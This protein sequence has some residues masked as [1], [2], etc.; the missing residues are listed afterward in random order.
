[1]KDTNSFVESRFHEM[2]M[3]KNGQERLKMGFSMFRTARK[4]VIASIK[5]DNPNASMKDIK[6]E[7]FLRFYA[8]EFSTEE[9][10]KI[11]NYII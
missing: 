11:L 5:E 10:E 8:H 9:Q 3:K 1:M 7:L 4:Q 6:K 2:M